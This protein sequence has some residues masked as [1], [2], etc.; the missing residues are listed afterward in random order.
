MPRPIVARIHP[1]AV[2]HNLDL[3]QRRTPDSRVWAV[4]KANAYGHGIERIYPALANADGIALLD[5]D[6]AV[7]VRELGWKKP[8]LLLEGIFTPAD[9]AIA[10]EFGLTV[11]VHCTEQLDLLGAANVNRPI[12]INLKMNSGMICFAPPGSGHA[13]SRR[14]ARSR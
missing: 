7:R 14:S 9:V 8:I 6:E 12:P 10:D 4:V 5:L 1:D 13:Q 11:A 3:V 2:R